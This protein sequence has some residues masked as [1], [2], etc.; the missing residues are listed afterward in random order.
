MI[1]PTHTNLH[2]EALL[3]QQIEQGSKEAFNILYE[4]YWESAYSEAYK[5]LKDADQS[6]DVVQEIFTHIWLHR[7][8][9]HIDNLPAYLHIAIRNR[10]IKIV[11]KQKLT[12]P[13]FN[14]LEST[15]AE[16]WKADDELLWKEFLQSYETLVS[17][18]PPKRQ[19]IFRLHF[20]DDMP[21]KDIAMHLGLSRKTVQ[22]QL[23][24][25]I[26]KLRLSLSHLFTLVIIL[27]TRS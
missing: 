11:T 17:T 16:K 25:A 3:L 6:K 23:I 2:E 18:L 15:T 20:H 10:V 21:T 14:I 1:R 4:K 26:E 13:F 19:M 7:D 8:S 9:L 24:K 5:R 22:N 12:H 27:L